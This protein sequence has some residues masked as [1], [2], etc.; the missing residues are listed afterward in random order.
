MRIADANLIVLPDVEVGSQVLMPCRQNGEQRHRNRCHRDVSDESA[1]G[2]MTI[3]IPAPTAPS[4]RVRATTASIGVRM[5]LEH[6]LLTTSADTNDSPTKV[7]G[8][9][10]VHP[11][12]NP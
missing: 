7:F 12:V 5:S 9:F 4:D 11:E 6:A 10:H 3:A 8:W 1:D 2:G